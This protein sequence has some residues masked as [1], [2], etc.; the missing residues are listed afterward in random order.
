MVYLLVWLKN[1]VTC[2]RQ[3]LPPLLLAAPSQRLRNRQILETW[4]HLEVAP[5]VLPSTRPTSH[6][7]RAASG[8]GAELAGEARSSAG[9]GAERG[10]ARGATGPRPVM[11]LIESLQP[12]TVLHTNFIKQQ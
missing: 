5:T 1:S 3:Q 9:R 11:M 8:R 2:R 10:A 4:A 12:C 7:L 6:R